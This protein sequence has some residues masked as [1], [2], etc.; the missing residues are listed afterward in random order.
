M[1]AT[2]PENLTVAIERGELSKDELQELITLRAADL[3]F[4][5]VEALEGYRAG[6]LPDDYRG[7]DLALL[8]E[9]FLRG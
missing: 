3:G 8:V 5:F 4:S 9:M 2:A 7:A 1:A 6:S